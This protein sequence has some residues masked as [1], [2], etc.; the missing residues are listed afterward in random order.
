VGRTAVRDES[1]TVQA[2]LTCDHRIVDGVD[3]AE[4]LTTLQGA[5]EELRTAG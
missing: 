1:V 3:G 2:V 5:I 4:F